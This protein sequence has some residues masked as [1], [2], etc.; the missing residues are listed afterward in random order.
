MMGSA[1]EFVLSN[2]RFTNQNQHERGEEFCQTLSEVLLQLFHWSHGGFLF[3]VLRLNLTLTDERWI[4]E[5][6]RVKN[7]CRSSSFCFSS[8]SYMRVLLSSSLFPFGIREHGRP[9]PLDR[10]IC[11]QTHRCTFSR[12]MRRRHNDSCAPLSLFIRIKT[13]LCTQKDDVFASVIYKSTFFSCSSTMFFQSYQI[14]CHAL[15]NSRRIRVYADGLPREKWEL[16]MRDREIG[17]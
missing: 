2:A 4:G 13:Y 14:H 11:Y 3:L 15:I 8:Y 6:G 17:E 16:V 1:T 9:R 5:D 12:Q 10:K 7:A